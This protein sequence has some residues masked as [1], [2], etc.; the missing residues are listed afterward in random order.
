MEIPSAAGGKWWNMIISTQYFRGTMPSNR[1]EKAFSIFLGIFSIFANEVQKRSPDSSDGEFGEMK[2]PYFVEIEKSGKRTQKMSPP[3]RNGNG[4]PRKG[5]RK[6]VDFFTG[7]RIPRNLGACDRI[8][9]SYPDD[10]ICSGQ[11]LRGKQ[12]SPLSSRLWLLGLRP[13]SFML[14][15]LERIVF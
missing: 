9:R 2:L 3:S 6:P 13:R 10:K 14:P 1:G 11:V 15:G 8:V 5:T 12:F 7:L 4:I